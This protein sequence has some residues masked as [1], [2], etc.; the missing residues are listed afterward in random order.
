MVHDLISIVRI[1]LPQK[2]IP[3]VV[4]VGQ[5]IVLPRQGFIASL[6]STIARLNVVKERTEPQVMDRVIIVPLES[7]QVKISFFL[8]MN[9]KIV[10]EELGR[11][12]PGF[13]LKTLELIQRLKVIVKIV[14]KGTKGTLALIQWS[15][16]T[17]APK[18]NSKNKRGE[19]NVPFVYLAGI[20]RRTHHRQIVTN[21]PET[22]TAIKLNNRPVKFVTM[23]KHPL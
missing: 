8:M 16:V 1:P 10:Q 17:N 14:Q 7:G 22:N 23:K 20:N 5:T 6:T 12:K 21:V 11:M 4:N 3:E 19:I 18:V 2:K 13:N 15:D 9:V